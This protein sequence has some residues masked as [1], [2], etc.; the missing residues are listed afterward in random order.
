MNMLWQWSILTATQLVEVQAQ[1]K[2]TAFLD[3]YLGCFKDSSEA[4][5]AQG[6]KRD[7]GPF[8]KSFE[9]GWT[10]A[11]CREEATFNK[12]KF[13]ALQNGGQCWAGNKF[14]KYGPVGADS[15]CA[16]SGYKNGR[17]TTTERMQFYGGKYKNAVYYTAEQWF[18]LDEKSAMLSKGFFVGCYWDD[19]DR[20][21]DEDFKDAKGKKR[22]WTQVDSVEDCGKL[23]EANQL[24]FFAV[25]NGGECRM[26][27]KMFNTYNKY[28]PV[29]GNSYC[30]KKKCKKTSKK[31][32]NYCG[33][34]W[35]NAIY[36]TKESP[37]YPAAFWQSPDGD[38]TIRLAWANSYC[39]CCANMPAGG[40]MMAYKCVNNK[41]EVGD[42]LKFT[43]EG[44]LIKST[45]DPKLCI[46]YKG[47]KLEA[48]K[49]ITLEKCGA[50][51]TFQKIKL[52]DDM[53]IRFSDKIEFGFNIYLGIGDGDQLHGRKLKTYKVTAANNEAFVIRSPVPPTKKPT[54]VPTPTPPLT[55]LK[56][57]KGWS[58]AKGKCTI[59]ITTGA[60]CVV[61]PNFP[62]VYSDEQSCSVKL[63]KT[64]AVKP[65]VFATEKY[66]DQVKIGGYTLSGVHKK[67]TT[68][69]LQKGVDTIEWSSDFYLGGS[70]W[71][72][73]KTKKKQPQLPGKK[74]LVPKLAKKEAK[75]K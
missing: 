53:T 29:L 16:E 57:A 66:F 21:Y 17:E 35:V 1:P 40:Q 63:T 6:Q 22:D 3:S 36:Y 64:A 27:K 39:L 31:W 65:E 74:K 60:P 52:F 4:Q 18:T 68:I 13:F 50:K 2:K 7:L 15:Y 72:I 51:E 41:G 49:Q 44:G 67:F 55:G 8:Y 38:S 42:H 19:R 34:G 33:N 70:G 71:K 11:R 23:A 46:S 30:S 69:P 75:K 26:S 56:E 24:P 20:E 62:K 48:S 12:Y 32:G 9:K 45:K 61:S 37:Y 25:Q 54:P 5:A 47:K 14:G 73:C 58:V 10:I 43:V 28:P 59:D